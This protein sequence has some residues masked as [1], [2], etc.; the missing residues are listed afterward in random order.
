M[1]YIPHTEQDIKLMLSEIGGNGG[2]LY[3][4]DLVAGRPWVHLP[5]SMG[6]DRY[7]EL[8]VDEKHALLDDI[9]KRGI[10]LFFTH[11]LECAMALPVTDDQGRY[12]TTN[13]QETVEGMMLN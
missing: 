8:G 3:S 11:D 12:T 1:R 10:R 13:E 4:S 6:I 2:V 5:I 7:P 9:I